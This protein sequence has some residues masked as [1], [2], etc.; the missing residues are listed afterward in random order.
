MTDS[1]NS[2]HISQGKTKV[3]NL[4]SGALTE[5]NFSP[6]TSV[7]KIPTSIYPSHQILSNM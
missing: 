7:I 2:C 6:Y 3:D 1:T 4:F 5:T